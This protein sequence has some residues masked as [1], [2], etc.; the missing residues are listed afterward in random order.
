MS[1]VSWLGGRCGSIVLV[2]DWR[3]AKPIMDWLNTQED[4]VNLRMVVVAQSEKIFRRASTWASHQK[5]GAD[6]LVTPGFSRSIIQE[7]VASHTHAVQA[8]EVPSEGGELDAP[9]PT[10]LSLPSLLKAVPSS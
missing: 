10:P 1:L 9:V 7:M 3:E 4:G 8:T 5:T 6:I 2:A